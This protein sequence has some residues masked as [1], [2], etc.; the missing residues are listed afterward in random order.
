M[1]E[2]FWRMQTRQNIFTKRKS[3]FNKRVLDSLPPLIKD[4]LLDIVGKA[5]EF[6]DLQL[7]DMRRFRLQDIE[8]KK[9]NTEEQNELDYENMKCSIDMVSYILTSPSLLH[10]GLLRLYSLRCGN[11]DYLIA[12]PN[13]FKCQRLV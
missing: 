7:H 9:Q 1:T 4:E 5:R 3:P 2:H 10:I 6:G 13:H 8:N 12:G 11:A